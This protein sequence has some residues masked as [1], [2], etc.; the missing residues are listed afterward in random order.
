MTSMPLES[1]NTSRIKKAWAQQLTDLSIAMA[2]QEL[3]VTSESIQ[4]NTAS[5][6]A[7]IGR[8]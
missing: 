2:Y 3:D 8:F 1:C 4:P 7:I 5:I 6:V